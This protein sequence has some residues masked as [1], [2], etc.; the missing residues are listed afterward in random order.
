MKTIRLFSDTGK[1]STEISEKAYQKLLTQYKKFYKAHNECTNACPLT[2]DGLETPSGV[3]LKLREIIGPKFTY[4]Y[5]ENKCQVCQTFEELNSEK[6]NGKDI[7][8]CYAFGEE[9]FD[10]LEKMLIREGRL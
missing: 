1:R 9:A 8:P 4:T 6:F 10:R 7:C 3:C 5:Y 2:F